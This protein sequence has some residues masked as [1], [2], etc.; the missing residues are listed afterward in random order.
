MCA[1]YGVNSEC[2]LNQQSVPRAERVDSLTMLKQSMRAS[3]IGASVLY[4]SIT[5]SKISSDGHSPAC[6]CCFSML[7]T[8]PCFLILWDTGCTAGEDNHHLLCSMPHA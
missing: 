5:V 4:R 1:G 3:R 7:C 6:T 2:P 8:G